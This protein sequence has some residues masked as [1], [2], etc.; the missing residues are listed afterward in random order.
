MC[1]FNTADPWWIGCIFIIM[2]T[3]SMAVLDGSSQPATVSPGWS[4][5]SGS[6]YFTNREGLRLFSAKIKSDIHHGFGTFTEGVFHKRHFQLVDSHHHKHED[7]KDSVLIALAIEG[8]RIE[9]SDFLQTRRARAFET[10]EKGKIAILIFAFKKDEQV[11]VR[12]RQ[13]ASTRHLIISYDP[14]YLDTDIQVFEAGAKEET[15]K[16]PSRW[17]RFLRRIHAA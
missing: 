7:D 4:F 6:L 12:F 8:T 3:F 9:I 5:Q 15:K 16:P 14:G 17:Q 10:V 1:Y 13:G 2:K 11:F